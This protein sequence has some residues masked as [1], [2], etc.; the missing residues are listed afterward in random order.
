M[1][2]EQMTSLLQYTPNLV[3]HNIDLACFAK[4]EKT[5][6]IDRIEFLFVGRDAEER[7][8]NRH[9]ITN[10]TPAAISLRDIF[11]FIREA[12]EEMIRIFAS[13]KSESRTSMMRV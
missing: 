13:C 4:V 6:C 1:D 9:Q 3:N 7:R 8:D 2:R 11:D 12:Q 10:A 5:V